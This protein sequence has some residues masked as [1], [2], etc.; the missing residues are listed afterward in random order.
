M[1]EPRTAAGAGWAPMS[2]GQIAPACRISWSKAVSRSIGP[3]IVTVARLTGASLGEPAP[4]PDGRRHGGR[5]N[6]TERAGGP[7]SRVVRGGLLVERQRHEAEVDR[8]RPHP[9]CSAEDD[10]AAADANPGEVDPEDVGIPL[11]VRVEGKAAVH[12]RDRAQGP[13]HELP[14]A[15]ED[16]RAGD[17]P[18]L[19]IAQRATERIPAAQ[20][21][22][23]R[24]AV[25]HIGPDPSRTTPTARPIAG[26][27]LRSSPT[28]AVNPPAVPRSAC[29]CWLVAAMAAPPDR[30]RQ[31]RGTLRPGSSGS[32]PVP[33]GANGTGQSGPSTG[34]GR[35]PMADGLRGGRRRGV[36]SAHGS[37]APRPPR[38]QQPQSPDL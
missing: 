9:R 21:A 31:R 23:E 27:R 4:P 29:W 20:L 37:T 10:A 11:V 7:R 38:S 30:A 3:C 22:P 24:R 18:P 14:A 2:C 25:G 8:C 36:G 34:P 5:R 1:A 17:E 13:G 15:D 16:L 32:L 6:R 28:L 33:G 19:R 26:W 12:R 35:Q